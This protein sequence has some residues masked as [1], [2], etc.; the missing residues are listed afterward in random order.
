MS[1]VKRCLV[2]HV[3]RAPHVERLVGGQIQL[4]GSA[5]IGLS[6]P[7]GPAVPCVSYM[8]FFFF[9]FLGEGLWDYWRPIFCG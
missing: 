7:G 1:N 3:P 6:V 8:L 2:R 9:F 4:W 5:R